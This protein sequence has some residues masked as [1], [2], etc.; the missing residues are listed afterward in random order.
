MTQALIAILVIVS[1][2]ALM[3]FIALINLMEIRRVVCRLTVAG[4]TPEEVLRLTQKLQRMGQN[5]EAIS[6]EEPG[7]AV[8]R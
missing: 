2:I 3:A 7:G 5:L 1:L 6:K 4:M 8:R